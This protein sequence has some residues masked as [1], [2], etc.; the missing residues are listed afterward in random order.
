MF[1]TASKSGTASTR[2]QV[3]GTADPGS[4]TTSGSCL[5]WSYSRLA[6]CPMSFSDHGYVAVNAN[7]RQSVGQVMNLVAP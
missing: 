5:C 6:T 3:G 7:I 2:V 4:I 1:V